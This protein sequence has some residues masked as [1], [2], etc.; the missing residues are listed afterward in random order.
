MT[1]IFRRVVEMVIE[2]RRLLGLRH[3]P[4][5]LADRRALRR[6]GLAL[7]WRDLH[8]QLGDRL[9]G[10]PFDPHYFHQAGWLARALA[11]GRP[12][13]HVDI[14]SDVRLVAA[15]SAFVP[16]EF[17]DVRPLDVVLE[18][19][20][21]RAGSLGSLPFADRSVISLSCLHVIEHVGLGRYGDPLDADGPR[22]AAAELARVLS[23]GG[24]LMLSTPVGRPRVEFNAHRVFDPTSIPALFPGLT[25]D[26]FALVDDG[27]RF[28]PDV[29]P[30]QAIGAEYACGLYVLARPVE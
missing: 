10:T 21:C 25:L 6:A 26:R 5:F 12:A 3:L 2:P 16:I 30:E 11:A 27:G 20:T 1:R 18:G 4:R 8:P 23:P 14:G 15:L 19:L 29:R 13:Q 28:L 7:R 9:P 22:H 17:V 24:R